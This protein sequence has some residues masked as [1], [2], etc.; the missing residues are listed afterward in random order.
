MKGR[1]LEWLVS[2]EQSLVIRLTATGCGLSCTDLASVCFPRTEVIVKEKTMRKL[3]EGEVN[4]IGYEILR[5]PV[6]DENLWRLEY[7]AAHAL[8][9][10]RVYSR[11]GRVIPPVEVPMGKDRGRAVSI[12]S[13]SLR[14]SVKNVCSAE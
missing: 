2:P 10:I 1:F 5:I 7:H 11:D 14:Q 6:L 4:R 13:E 9:R 8:C 3:T 12:V